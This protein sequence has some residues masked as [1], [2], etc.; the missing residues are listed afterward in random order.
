MR[1]ADDYDHGSF[2]HIALFY[3]SAQ[4]YL[5]Y[6]VPFIA[7]G[8]AAGLPVLVAVPEPNLS[9]LRAA[10]AG[11]AGRAEPVTLTDMGRVGRNPG[12]ILGGVLG[13]FAEQHPSGPVRMI[14]EPVW[15]G[16][17]K[18]EYAACVQHEAL[19]NRAFNGRDI[20]VQCPYDAMHLD[21]D[22]LAE[23]EITH[24]RL[25]NAGHA[26]R[27]SPGFAP[28]SAWARYNKPLPSSTTAASY[29]L[30]GLTDLA[31]ARAFAARYTRWFGFSPSGIADMELI[32]NELTSNGLQ[33]GR[34][35]CTLLLWEASGQLICQ[36]RS[37][38][39]LTDPMAGHWPIIREGAR[40]RGLFVVNATADLVR[41]H[42][43][44]TGTTVQANLRIQRSA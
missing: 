38:G 10:L 3:R 7:D 29:T 21:S 37:S 19:L 14:D 17:S 20:T 32:V 2:S 26:D 4:E 8:V 16:R 5:D 13:T 9:L 41:V 22:S 40:G 36:V 30:H 42:I 11:I 31:G 1:T 18:A 44:A 15:N 43:A 34:G 33:H 39:H 6:L 28:D 24:P 12:H 25:G 27:T 35:P 23:A